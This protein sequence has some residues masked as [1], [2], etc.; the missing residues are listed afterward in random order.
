[1]ESRRLL[2]RKLP[3]MFALENAI[4]VLGGMTVRLYHFTYP[5]KLG[6]ILRAGIAPLRSGGPD[7]PDHSEMVGGSPCVWLTAAPTREYKGQDRAI[8]AREFSDDKIGSGWLP[9]ATIRITVRIS[10][11]DKLLSHYRSWV[12]KNWQ[13]GLPLPDEPI[14]DGAMGE[15][16]VYFGTITPGKIELIRPAT[17]SAGSSRHR[18]WPAPEGLAVADAVR[19][20]Q[21]GSGHAQ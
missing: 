6:K 14:F 5:E 17:Y 20:R 2:H 11:R 15:W 9:L 3:G 1:M 16:W 10:K 8:F 7:H 13:P 4:D 18:T 12:R 19:V 21:G